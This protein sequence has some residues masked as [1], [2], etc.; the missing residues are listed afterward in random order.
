MKEQAVIIG[1]GQAGAQGA[2]SLRAAGYNGAIVLIGA[3]KAAPY[4]RPPLSKAYLQGTMSADR[5]ALK[6]DAFYVQNDITLR[7]GEQVTVIDRANARVE[8][9]AG[10]AIAY[11]RLL[12]ATGAPPRR[13]HC[14]GT[15][16]SGVHYLRTAEDCEGLRPVL[17]TARRL[18]IVGA[19][20]IGL[21]VAA[22]ARK[23]GRAVTVLEAQSRVL[24][25]VAGP[26][27]SGFFDALHR[28]HGADLRL[29][30]AL[31]H[32][33]GR[34]V[35]E[36]AVLMSGETIDCDAVLIGV[37][38]VPA[39]ALAEAAGL[40]ID[41]GVSTD[42]HAATSD[43]A[44]FAAGDCASHPSTLYGRRMR[45]ESVPNA[46][47]QA[48]V[49]GANMAG[50]NAVY[51]SVPW[52]WSDQYDVKL[53]TAGVADG[54][55]SAVLRGDP[56]SGRFSLWSLKAGRVLAVDAVND[57]AAF[58]VSKKIIAAKTP[59]DAKTLADPAADLKSLAS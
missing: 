17:A 38:A 6:P 37:G 1:A 59:V 23:A 47:E 43:P 49:A 4:Q 8:T 55:D 11:D 44:I 30:A 21:E 10:A 53:Q 56:A 40:V 12:L 35:V 32:L 42:E 5:L 45:L 22:S 50:G 34:G 31:S 7:L 15:E 51:D 57:P 25:R 20:Y 19:G 16:L 33:E 48:K 36:R 41:N 46:I 3:E 28:L 2:Q 13:L 14:P 26:E 9:A 58:L 54:A 29:N 27:I 24:A 18:V 52:F 39:A